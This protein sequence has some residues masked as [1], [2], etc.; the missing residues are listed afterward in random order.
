MCYLD[1]S[2]EEKSLKTKLDVLEI[3]IEKNLRKNQTMVNMTF[4]ICFGLSVLELLL[5][6]EHSEIQKKKENKTDIRNSV[7]YFDAN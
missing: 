6:R 3:S 1:F 7:I 5:T 4:Q 2:A